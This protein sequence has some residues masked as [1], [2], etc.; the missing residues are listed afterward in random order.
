MWTWHNGSDGWGFVWMM[1]GTVV[2]LLP[3]ILLVAWALLG[4][5]R[6]WR[7]RG[8]TDASAA[9]TEPD[10]RELA[11]RTYARGE[12]DRERYQQMIEDLDRAADGAAGNA[13][14]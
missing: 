10:A 2:V 8:G 13:R 1:V 14:S 6:P 3:L 7:A 5:G 12:I 11:R 4:D 9:S